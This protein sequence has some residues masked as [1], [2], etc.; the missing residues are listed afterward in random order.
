MTC[1]PARPD[2]LPRTWSAIPRRANRVVEMYTP[3]TLAERVRHTGLPHVGRLVDVRV[4]VDD[5]PPLAAV[6]GPAWFVPAPE[7]HRVRDAQAACDDHHQRVL[8]GGGD[9][10]RE[11]RRV[12]IGPVV[13]ELG[14]AVHHLRRHVEY[15]EVQFINMLF[16]YETE[17]VLR[18]SRRF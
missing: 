9:G 5:V 1:M 15:K 10:I 16:S 17:V 11:E 18:N 6:P 14:D 2:S 8:G 12:A 4:G 13:A 7:Q 3:L